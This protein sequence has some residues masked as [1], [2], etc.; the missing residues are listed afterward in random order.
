MKTLYYKYKNEYLQFKSSYFENINNYNKNKIIQ[1]L[2]ISL[3]RKN[4]I[5]IQEYC[6]KEFNFKIEKCGFCNNYSQIDIDFEFISY[7]NSYLLIVIDISYPNNYFYCKKTG[8]PGKKLNPNSIE[9]VSKSKKIN[10]KNAIKIIHERNNSPFYKEN[11]SSIEEYKNYQSLN[12]RLNENEY[13]NYIKNL[14]YSKTIEYYYDKYGKEEGKKIWD[15]I[16]TKK[17]SMSFNF[18]LKKYNYNYKKAIIEYKNRIKTIIPTCHCKKNKYS[19]ISFKIF[20][21][22]INI[23]K[24]NKNECF[25]GENEYMLKYKDDNYKYNYRNFYYDFTDI[26]NKIIIEYN[27]L[28]WHPHKNKMTNEQ[29]IN[30]K[31][32]FNKNINPIDIE[33][34]DEFK[35]KIAIENGFD[36]ITIWDVDSYDYN[37]KKVKDYYDRKLYRIN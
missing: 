15:D 1:S 13:N 4:K 5:S 22:L 26:N 20:N 11:Y 33:K 32:P 30:W 19:K 7:K 14:K 24:L 31:H 17:D 36:L 29:Y 28:I 16:Q 21:E 10:K 34:K 2:K 12:K 8:C 3:T 23:L 27:G 6:N 37:I 35:K 18:F 9:F 25:Y